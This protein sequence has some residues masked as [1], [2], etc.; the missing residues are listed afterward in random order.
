MALSVALNE[1]RLAAV[2]AFL[3]LGTDP[4]MAQIYDGTRPAFGAA[5]TG[6]LLTTI[7]LSEPMGT[8]AGG[9][10]SVATTAEALI[11]N[12][13]IAT[14]ARVTN[15]NGTIAWDCDVSATGGGG[16]L[17]LPSTALYAGGYARIVSGTLG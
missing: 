12:T 1:A 9:A 4:A 16:E 11:V 13:G 15:G 5:P 8:V 2:E 3:A 6:N 17:Q 14:W 7:L 10:L